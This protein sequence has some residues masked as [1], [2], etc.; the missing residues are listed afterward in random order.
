MNDAL[1]RKAGSKYAFLAFLVSIFL[2][3]T[4]FEQAGANPTMFP[5]Y[6]VAGASMFL[7]MPLAAIKKIRLRAASVLT[8]V[9]LAAI[10]FHSLVI[11]PVPAQFNL[12]I[13]ANMALAILIYETSFH[14]R[15]EFK[16]AISWILAV[17]AIVIA[18]QALLFYVFTSRIFDFHKLVFGSDSRFVENFLNIARFSGLQVEPGTYANYIACLTAILVLSSEFSVRLLSICFVAIISIFLTNSGSSVYFVPVLLALL[19]ILG[20]KKIRGIHI[21]ILLLAVVIYLHFSGIWAHLENRFMEHDDGSLS[22]RIIGINAYMATTLEEKIL[23]LGFDSEPCVRCFYQDIGVT[24]NLVTRGGIIV[25]LAIAVLMA[26]SVIVNG[27]V[28]ATILFLIPL[29]EKMSF[30]EAPIWLFML[31]A[32][33]ALKNA[34]A[35]KPVREDTGLRQLP[36]LYC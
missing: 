24:F 9:A 12:L 2:F 29:N 27:I 4:P 33:T 31:F 7:L 25:S 26:R 22:Q 32:T 18:I 21:V 1:S 8:L 23:G 36:R 16:A 35:P 19:A 6:F 17:N 30:Y 13:C 10:I 14:W 34:N 15:R 5:K 11:K 28:L 20:K 3:F